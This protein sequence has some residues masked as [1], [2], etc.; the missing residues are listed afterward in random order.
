MISVRGDRD[1]LFE[2]VA[3]L[4]D[5]AIKFTPE[6]GRVEL[7][8]L[9]TAGGPVVRVDDT[10]RARRRMSLAGIRSFPSPGQKPARSW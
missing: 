10:G 3:N 1:L 7:A 5:N 6:N 8:L 9:D 4:V 2:A